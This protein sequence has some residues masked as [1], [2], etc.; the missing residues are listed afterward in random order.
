MS[1]IRLYSCL[2]RSKTEPELHTHGYASVNSSVRLKHGQKHRLKHRL[3][4]PG[5]TASDT[6]QLVR[7]F[8]VK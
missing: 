6:G 7:A 1:H 3:I 2:R 8:P 4:T 5:H